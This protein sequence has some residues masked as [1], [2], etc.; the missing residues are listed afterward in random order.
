MKFLH[1]T[2]TVVFRSFEGH[3]GQNDWSS[4]LLGISHEISISLSIGI[5]NRSSEK[6]GHYSLSDANTPCISLVLADIQNFI[7]EIHDDPVGLLC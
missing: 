3:L 4:G 2:T 1:K 7:L 5:D 6:T